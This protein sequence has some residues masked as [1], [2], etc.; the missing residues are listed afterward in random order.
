MGI[1][2]VKRRVIRKRKPVEQ[3]TSTQVEQGEASVTQSGFKVNKL[4][5]YCVVT[6]PK[7]SQEKREEVV[8]T[9]EITEEQKS[10][11]HT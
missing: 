1:D 8:R 4:I 2:F 10:M 5:R 6:V 7:S 3:Q 11:G 9:G